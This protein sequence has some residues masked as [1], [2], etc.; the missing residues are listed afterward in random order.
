L[1]ALYLGLFGREAMHLI[2]GVR[3]TGIDEDKAL[4]YRH[5]LE[6]ILHRPAIRSGEAHASVILTFSTSEGEIKIRRKWNF[7]K[8]GRIKD[9]NS[10]DGEEVLIE[11]DGRPHI[12]ATWQ[13][14]NYQIA[15]MLF[16][17]NVM[18]CFFFDGEQAQARVE[19]AG[20]KALLDAVNTLYGT[21]ILDQ[22]N[23]SL[24]TFIQNEKNALR[25][26][27]GTIKTD[28]LDE[29]R[30]QLEKAKEQQRQIDAELTKKR[31][32][33]DQEEASRTQLNNDLFQLVGDS[34]ADIEEFTQT[35]RALE[36]EEIEARQELTNGLA[37]LAAPL[38]LT[39]YAPTVQR[40]LESEQ[41]RDRWLLLK[42]EA[43]EK[44]T[45]ILDSVLPEKREVPVSPPLEQS[46]KEQL[47][48][49]LSKALE[50]LWSPPPDG[51]AESYT[52]QF[53]G[54]SERSAVLSKLLRYRREPAPDVANAVTKWSSVTTRLRE[55]KRRFE[56]I[57][58]IEP[59]LTKLKEDIQAKTDAIRTL[60]SEVNGLENRSKGKTQEINDLKATIGQMERKRNVADP[61]K[62]KLDVAHRVTM[63]LEEAKDQL[64]PL[65]KSKL[66]EQCTTHFRGMISDEYRSFHVRIDSDP[67]L[68]GPNGEVVYVTSLSGAQKRAFGLAFTLAVA[69]V[70]GEKAPIVIDTPVGNMDSRY[71]DRV[72]RYVSEAA[73]GQVIFLSHDEEINRVYKERLDDRVVK[74][75]LVTFEA[76]EEG[77]GVSRVVDDKYFGEA[78]A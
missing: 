62:R 63:V 13:E 34:S 55:T 77:S 6:R 1:I 28:E 64:I 24:Q 56:S 74:T 45:K 26:E 58:D 19:A 2:E 4:H 35:I 23:D 25:K 20:G 54:E 29:K 33:L 32:E 36:N 71:R 18:P 15:E 53:L 11:T 7:S 5:V 39:R 31:Q 42:D 22:L 17:G 52:Y 57:R 47:R 40:T 46:Q 68:E 50:L 41:V 21:G 60:H 73:A 72:L 9:L 67:R 38:A 12:Y 69:D 10:R 65:C 66:E 75:M 43:S 51:C 61:V 27:V 37:Q 14:A 3:M 76:V 16:P 30:D 48:S 8:G 44:A 59:K 78:A 70:S 49:Q